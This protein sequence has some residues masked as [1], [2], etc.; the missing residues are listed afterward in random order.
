MRFMVMVKATKDSE[1]G[2]M[3]SEQALADWGRYNEELVKNGILLAAEG[4]QP[5]SK[6]VRVR[7]SGA[8]RTVIDGPFSETKELVAGFSLLQ[9]KS[10]EE[11]IEWVKRC[12]NPMPGDSEVEIRQV[13]EWEDFGVEIAPERQERK[14]QLRAQFEKQPKS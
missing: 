9:V 10:K 11:A 2:V 12:P 3:P 13:M 6:G 5:S 4:L 1:A 7:F 14:A 8:K